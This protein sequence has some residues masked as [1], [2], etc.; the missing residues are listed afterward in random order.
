M[1]DTNRC[2]SVLYRRPLTMISRKHGYRSRTALAVTCPEGE[3]LGLVEV[4]VSDGVVLLVVV[5]RED[6]GAAALAERRV[7]GGRVRVVPLVT[8]TVHRR[9]RSAQLLLQ[10]QHRALHPL[11]VLVQL[12]QELVQLC[13]HNIITIRYSDNII[14]QFD[15][16]IM[17]AL[18]IVY[19]ILFIKRQS[20]RSVS[21]LYVI[22]SCDVIILGLVVVL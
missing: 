12:L 17:T 15:A 20:A 13:N 9:L 14:L 1:S 7:A 6:G 2:T 18:N 21:K 11:H 3:H 22:P 10:E 16:N 8:H 4:S 19:T 5:E